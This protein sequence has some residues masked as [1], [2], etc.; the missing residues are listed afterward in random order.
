MAEVRSPGKQAGSTYTWST[1]FF[2]LQFVDI[3]T[4]KGGWYTQRTTG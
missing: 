3:R 2:D 1:A 4:K